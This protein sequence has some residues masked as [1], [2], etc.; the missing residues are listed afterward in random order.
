[1]TGGFAV[2]KCMEYSVKTY[3][4]PTTAPFR[5]TTLDETRH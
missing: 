5:N 2:N 3:R 4:H 1:L